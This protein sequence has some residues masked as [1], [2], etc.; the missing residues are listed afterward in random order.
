MS[1]SRIDDV[2]ANRGSGHAPVAM[3]QATEHRLSHD[4]ALLRWVDRTRLRRILV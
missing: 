3:V 1:K 4:P 2:R